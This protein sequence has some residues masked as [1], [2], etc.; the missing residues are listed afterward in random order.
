MRQN[1]LSKGKKINWITVEFFL[2]TCSKM[3]KKYKDKI[4]TSTH[5]ANFLSFSGQI[6][7][8]GFV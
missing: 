3:F 1:I 8:V 5:S 6:E 4:V 7:H 2:K